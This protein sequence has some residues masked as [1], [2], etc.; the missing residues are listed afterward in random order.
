MIQARIH[1]GRIELQEP[2][3]EEW[4]GHYVKIMPLTPDDPIPDLEERLA[5]FHALGPIEF[6]PGERGMI[7]NLWSDMDRISD[8]RAVGGLKTG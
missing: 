2:I 4:E 1:N 6:D 8:F 3:P 5:E 7:T